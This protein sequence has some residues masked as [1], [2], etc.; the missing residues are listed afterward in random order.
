MQCSLCKGKGVWPLF[1]REDIPHYNLEL[2]FDR[3][4]ALNVRRGIVD[5]YYCPDCAF[6]FNAA[7]DQGLADYQ[8]SYE[9]SR[10]HS[11]KF[12]EYMQHVVQDFQDIFGIEGKTVLEIG[13]GDGQFLEKMRSQYNFNG[14]GFDPSAKTD[15]TT[16]LKLIKGYFQPASFRPEVDIVVLR[17]VL[18]HQQNA[19]SFLAAILGKGSY[20][21]KVRLYVEV[22]CWEW[23]VKHH[24]FNAFSYEH[25]SY[26]SMDSLDQVLEME[27][28]QSKVIK[29]TF[30]GEYLQYFGERGRVKATGPDDRFQR[31]DTLASQTR[32]FYKNTIKALDQINETIHAHGQDAVIWGAAGK[33][34]TLINILGLSYKTMEFVVDINPAR[35]KTYIPGGGQQVVAPIQLKQIKPKYIYITNSGYLEEIKT[36]VND[37]GL[38]VEFILLDRMMEGCCR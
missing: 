21:N 5:F 7:F 6:A 26:Y 3:D 9:S 1:R 24:S 17:H 12:L 14:Y 16:D 19:S 4:K 10:G 28:F 13:C 23:I 22:P 27:G 29:Y 38:K 33:G 25:C 37:L 11:A 8:V 31:K 15:S 30:E 32:I 34:T 20:W 2:I 36:I 18:E 35:H